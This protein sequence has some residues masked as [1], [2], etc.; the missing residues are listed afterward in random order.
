MMS[1]H[2]PRQTVMKHRHHNPDQVSLF[3]EDT[4]AMPDPTFVKTR[5]TVKEVSIE[6]GREWVGRWHY[7]N[8]MPGTGNH[9]WGI[10]C[11]DMIACVVISLPNNPH[12][13]AARYGLEGWQGNRE[14]SRVV[15]H[16]D[17]PKN[18]TSRAVRMVAAHL[19]A[20]QGIE[21]LF[22]YADTG[23]NH[24]GGIYQ[25]LNCVYVGLTASH[26]GYL[27]DGEPIHS[28]TLTAVYG[29]SAWPRIRDMLREL[30]RGDLVRIPDAETPKHTYI[31]PC[32][33][34]ASRRA[35]RKALAG[36]MLSYP[37]R[38]S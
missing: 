20:T 24:H 38:T 13:V 15:A 32:G 19:H 34:P 3:G 25:A 5:W 37:K 17:A 6:T 8:R 23:Q 30:G 1:P 11:P 2:L 36:Y 7:A 21:W 33:G 27:L 9:C 29:T 4:D 10:F 22:S 12:G 16:P 14:I 26:A 18:T 28:R 35:I 31:L